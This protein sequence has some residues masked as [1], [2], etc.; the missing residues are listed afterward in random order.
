VLVR[1]HGPRLRT[2]ALRFGGAAAADDIVQE[3]FIA[4]WRAAARWNPGGPAYAAWLTRVAV[5]RAIDRD[6]RLRLRRFFGLAAA[7]NAP[8]PAAPA[9]LALADRRELAAVMRDLGSLPA[10]QRMAVLLAASE[11]A[12]NAGVAAALGISEGAA[13]QLLVRARRRLRELRA[14]RNTLEGNGR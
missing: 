6:R 3:T 2:L 8:D 10:R 7:E 1:R 9:D 13:E 12:G 11:E 14:A 5:N 4:A